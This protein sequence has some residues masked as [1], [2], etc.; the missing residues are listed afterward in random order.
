[1]MC[2]CTSEN[3]EIPRCAIAHLRSGPSDHPGMTEA[4]IASSLALLAMTMEGKGEGQKQLRRVGKGA[5][6]PCP[7]FLLKDAGGHAALCP[8]CVSAMRMERTRGKSNDGS[9]RRVRSMPV[10]ECLHRDRYAGALGLARSLSG[11]PARAR[12]GVRDL[13][14]KLAQAVSHHQGQ[15]GDCAFRGQDHENH[16]QLLRPLRHP[17]DLRARALTAHGEHHARAVQR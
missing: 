11:E 8:P 16:P 3:L 13:C 9:G 7:P 17:A 2:N 6:A 15:G 5:L 1:M 14:R 10:R 4:W 12:C